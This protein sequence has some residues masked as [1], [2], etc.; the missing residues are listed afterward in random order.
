MPRPDA[1]DSAGRAGWQGAGSDLAAAPGGAAAL[2]SRL[3]R[4]E[5]AEHTQMLLYV[6]EALEAV[7]GAS[8]WLGRLIQEHMPALRQ[9]GRRG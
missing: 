2:E 5:L 3:L 6:R 9:E 7:E 1:N 4:H 8:R